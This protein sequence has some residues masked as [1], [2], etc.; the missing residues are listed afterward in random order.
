MI[1]KRRLPGKSLKRSAITSTPQKP[2]GVAR[3]MRFQGEFQCGCPWPRDVL[4]PEECP[5][6]AG[7]QRVYE[8]EQT[9]EMT[10]VEIQEAAH[11]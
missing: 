7:A 5:N 6:H 10:N 4:A 8:L 2:T 11:G 3:V 1:F 9:L